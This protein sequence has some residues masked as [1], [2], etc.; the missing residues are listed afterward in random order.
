MSIFWYSFLVPGEDDKRN[1]LLENYPAVQGN[2]IVCRDNGSKKFARF[3]TYL[4]Y[5]RFYFKDTRPEHRNDFEVIM[6]QFFQK[7]FFDIDIARVY[8]HKPDSGIT[9]FCTTSKAVMTLEQ[10]TVAIQ[11]LVSL[12][13]KTIE[14]LGGKDGTVLVFTS[15]SDEKLS[16]HIVV[17]K[18]C[19]SDNKENRAF[20]DTIMKDYQHSEIVDH[21]VYSSIRQLRMYR[22]RKHGSPRIKILS[23]ELTYNIKDGSFG[24]KFPVKPDNE[25]HAELMIL[26]SSLVGNTTVCNVLPSLAEPSIPRSTTTLTMSELT[27]RDIEQILSLARSKMDF[28]FTYKVQEQGEG[29][30]LISL[31]RLRPSLCPTCQR[32]HEHENPYI[33]VYGEDKSIA[34]DCRRTPDGKR[35]YLGKLGRGSPAPSPPVVDLPERPKTNF[36]KDLAKIETACLPPRKTK[37][38]VVTIG[39]DSFNQLFF[40]TMYSP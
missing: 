4:D 19:V 38:S 16:Y 7:P 39:Q 10:A 5:A 1:S 17:D 36:F 9:S 23:P 21:G 28:P 15:H 8:V 35:F 14:R 12:I 30:A 29:S 22:S 32:S 18:W 24:Y 40:E 3:A 11:Q 13:A 27:D 37:P 26:G 34:F 2:L 25:D 33:V 31:K 6:G 20:H